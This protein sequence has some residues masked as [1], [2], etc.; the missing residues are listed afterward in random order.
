[1]GWPAVSLWPSRTAMAEMDDDAMMAAWSLGPVRD[2]WL[3]FAQ[4]KAV[5]GSMTGARVHDRH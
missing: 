2:R 1:M 5:I 4:W 3:V